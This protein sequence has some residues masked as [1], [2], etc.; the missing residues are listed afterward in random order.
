MNIELKEITVFDLWQGYEDHEENG[1]VGYGGKLDIR[2]PFQRE[3][4]Y[5][6]K[7]RDAVIDTVTKNFPLNVMY[8][9]VRDDGTFEVIDGQQRT[10]SICQYVNGDFSYLFRYFHNL[11]KDERDQILN[12]KLMVYICSGSESEKLQWFKTINIAG[13]KLTD[14]E[15]RN[16]VYAGTWVSDAKRYFSKSGCVASSIGIDYLNGSPIRQEYMETAIEWISKGNIEA[17]MGN[18]QHDPNANALWIY[19]QSVI[20][21]V[22]ATFTVKRKKFM[23]GVEWGILYNKYKDVIYDTKVI[24]QE[25]A[26]L[27]AD[28]DVERKHGIYAYILTRDE[29]HLGIRRFSDNVK[30]KVYEKQGGICVKCGKHFDIDGMEADHIKP[31][32]EGGETVE[33]NCQLLCKDDNRRKSG[34]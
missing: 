6:D 1:V 16:A 3:F 25:T 30:Q 9:A 20:A 2:P 23:K 8:W 14:Q 24:E 4:I 19:F 17:Y 7:Q 13:V 32:H 12:Y 26:K 33:A 18:H 11:G 21:W 22:N 31:W 27:I 10:I 28:D 29:R 15:L 5:K 34:W